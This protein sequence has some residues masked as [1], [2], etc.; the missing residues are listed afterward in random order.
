MN[1]EILAYPVAINEECSRGVRGQHMDLLDLAVG[2]VEQY[3][4]VRQMSF[5]MAKH[6]IDSMMACSSIP[7][8]VVE[9]RIVIRLNFLSMKI[10]QWQSSP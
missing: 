6:S 5:L 2:S 4:Q 1:P 9:N 8:F 3:K 10:L 7:V